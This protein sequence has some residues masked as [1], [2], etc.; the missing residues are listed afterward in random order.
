M[1]R[2][3]GILAHNGCYETEPGHKMKRAL[4]KIR[5]IDGFSHAFHL[6][7]TVALPVLIY[8]FVRIDLAQLAIATIFLSKWRMFAVRPRYWLANL[9]ANSVDI[10]VGVSLVIFMTQTTSQL[11]QM[12]WAVMYVLW[13]LLIKPST[14]LLGAAAQAIIAQVLGLMAV[15]LAWGGADAYVLILATWLVCYTAAHHFFTGFD[16]PYTKFLTNIWAFFGGSLAWICSH[17]LLYYGSVSQPTLLLTVLG[18][19]LGSMYYLQK[20]DKLTAL[21]RRQFI[22][23][24]AAIIIVVLVFSDWGDK[25]V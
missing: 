18:F 22:F 25:A 8:I 7:L 13:L 17:W 14:T 12:I 9:Q 15:Y 16:E 20:S 19:G 21:L 11:W 6:I 5:P 2:K 3:T 24:M 1:Q 10:L 4:T 23:I